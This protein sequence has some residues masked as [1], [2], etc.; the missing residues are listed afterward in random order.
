MADGCIAAGV[1]NAAGS[2]HDARL[3]T[4]LSLTE[5]LAYL[6]EWYLIA[7]DVAFATSSRLIRGLRESEMREMSAQDRALALT[8]HALLAKIR[9]AAEWGIAGT[10]L[11][12]EHH[13]VM[14]V[15]GLNNAW[16][17]LARRQPSDD[18]VGRRIIS[19][20]CHRLHNLR[21]RLMDTCQIRTVFSL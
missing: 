15:I 16:Q 12:P 19:E 10:S 4:L 9:V 7:V 18:P 17:I 5:R 1:I 21:C 13:I 14:D 6:P 8:A 11:L 3:E 2:W 20:V